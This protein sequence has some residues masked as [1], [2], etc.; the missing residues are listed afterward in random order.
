MS[1]KK[2]INGDN[3]AK[4][5][6]FACAPAIVL[7]TLMVICSIPMVGTSDAKTVTKFDGNITSKVIDF[8]TRGDSAEL[9]FTVPKDVPVTSTYIN[10]STADQG[11]GNFPDQPSIDVGVDGDKEWMF[12]GTGYG[13][14]GKQTL[15]SD[16]NTRY[17]HTFTSAG[18]QTN[19]KIRLP[20]CPRRA[21]T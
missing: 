2:N 11:T 9:S 21:W 7:I 6:F 15:F 19:A 16:N 10:V 14:F 8:K 12:Q 13:T 20:R 18:T 1:G 3:M 5:N 17:T 4:I